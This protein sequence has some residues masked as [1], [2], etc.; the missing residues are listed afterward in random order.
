[1]PVRASSVH[2]SMSHFSNAC[3]SV[4]LQTC[5]IPMCERNALNC[6]EAGQPSTRTLRVWS[7]LLGYTRLVL[8]GRRT[9]GVASVDFVRNFLVGNKWSLKINLKCFVRRSKILSVT[10]RMRQSSA[11]L[12]RLRK[13]PR[14][15]LRDHPS[16]IHNRPKLFS[17]TAI[18]GQHLA[19]DP[20]SR[21]PLK[22]RKRRT[23]A[24]R[25]LG[26]SN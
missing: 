23:R 12:L 21:V 7:V 22:I 25:T 26:L 4:E 19:L 14:P 3:G 11:N 17:H 20:S 16:R 8:H 6:S 1:M 2:S 24:R 13:L 10:R 15:H 18:R 9:A 5:Q